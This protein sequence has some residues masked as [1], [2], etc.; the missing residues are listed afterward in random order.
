[1]AEKDLVEIYIPK[2]SR[3]D[4]ERFIAVNGERILVQT[5]KKVKVPKRFAEVIENSVAMAHE[6]AEYIESNTTV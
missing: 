6:A 1:M 5:G 4:N 2:E 3:S